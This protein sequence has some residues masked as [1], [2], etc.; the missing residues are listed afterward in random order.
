MMP[1]LLGTKSNFYMNFSVMLRKKGFS[2]VEVVVAVGIFALAIVGVIGLLSPTNKAVADVADSDNATRVVSAVQQ[3]LQQLAASGRFT[4]VGSVVGVGSF[5]IG[6]AVSDGLIQATAPADP[7][8]GNTLATSGTYN[9][10]T[11]YASRDGSKVGLTGDATVWG[12][13]AATNNTLKY[14]EI[15]LIRNSTLSPNLTPANADTA[16]GY[17]AYTMRIRWPAYTPDGNEFKI[18]TQKSVL[19]VPGAIT[20]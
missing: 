6:A 8:D 3:G 4:T 10:F 17:L 19:I 12:T 9:K 15:M 5:T 13:A 11:I 20:R 18:H 1:L 14:F 2:L 16:S 7:T